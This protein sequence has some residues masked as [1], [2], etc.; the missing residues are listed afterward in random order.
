MWV[1]ALPGNFLLE[2]LVGEDVLVVKEEL[3][4][5]LSLKMSGPS[6]AEV[7]FVRTASATGVR[8]VKGGRSCGPQHAT[9]RCCSQHCAG[10][11]AP[12]R[13]VPSS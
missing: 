11:A 4:G 6:S 9:S 2:N 1:P 3:V 10:R 8:R 7:A 5:P 12:S 13:L